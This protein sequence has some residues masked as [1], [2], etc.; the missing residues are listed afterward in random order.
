VLFNLAIV[1]ILSNAPTQADAIPMTTRPA[2]LDAADAGRTRLGPLVYRGGLELRSTD[3]RFG[4]LSGLLVDAGGSQLVA[5]S[6]TGRWFEARLVSDSQGRLTGIADPSL[7]PLKDAAGRPFAKK[8][9]GD[10]EALTRLADGSLLVGFENRHRLLRYSRP[11]AAGEAFPA[12]AGLERAPDNAGLEALTRL[13]DGRILAICEDFRTADGTEVRGWIG[14]TPWRPL[15]LATS[16][17]FLPT[18][19]TAL[20]GGD[21]LLVERR[22]P[23]LAVRLR[24]ITAAEIRPDARLS[25]QE[26]ARFEGSLS[27]DNFEGASAR[28]GAAGET[29]LYLLS[30]DNQFPLQRTLLLMFAMPGG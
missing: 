13:A 10:A 8:V 24:R 11:G 9:W 28:S 4:G 12:P 3:P 18:A 21:V 15:T 1:T 17:G 22:F 23:F 6:D 2:L 7:S 26:I 29:L 25:P 20:P 5:V 30:D 16:E 27:F 19:L 14:P